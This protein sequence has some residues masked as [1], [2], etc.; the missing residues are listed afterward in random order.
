MMPRRGLPDL[1]LPVLT[2]FDC[3]DRPDR[4]LLAHAGQI[5]EIGGQGGRNLWAARLDEAVRLA[6]RPVVLVAYGVSCF[7]VAWWARLSP[8]TYVEKVA[9]AVFVRPLEHVASPEQRFDGPKIRMAFPSVLA[10]TGAEAAALARDWGSRLAGSQALRPVA[11][12]LA[13]LREEVPALAAKVAEPVV[14]RLR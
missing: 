10:D 11:E 14:A 1:D 7:A 5:V 6:E 9:G 3:G 12:L 4:S 2:I 8:T 13:T